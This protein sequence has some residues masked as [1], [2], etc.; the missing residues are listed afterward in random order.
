MSGIK[1]VRIVEFIGQL[2]PSDFAILLFLI[3]LSEVRA[4]ED[5][6]HALLLQLE[7]NPTDNVVKRNLIE[8][9]QQLRRPEK[10]SEI[11]KP[12]EDG[13]SALEVPVKNFQSFD[14]QPFQFVNTS[15]YPQLCRYYSDITNDNRVKKIA[16][17]VSMR[18]FR[19]TLIGPSS[20]DR[21]EGFVGVPMILIP[22]QSKPGN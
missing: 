15:G 6:Y 14:S 1:S 7:K 5:A 12:V 11:T 20:S 2:D 4:R 17:C 22:V 13:I 18:G 16:A 19:S 8:V 21:G 9:Q 3:I 10:G